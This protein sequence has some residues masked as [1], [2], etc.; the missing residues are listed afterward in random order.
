MHGADV[1]PR[2]PGSIPLSF[3]MFGCFLKTFV[4]MFWILKSYNSVSL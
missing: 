2:L 4:M 1:L 3:Q